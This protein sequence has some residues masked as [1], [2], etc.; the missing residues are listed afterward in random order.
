MGFAGLLVV[1]GS[2]KA[3]FSRPRSLFYPFGGGA[4]L[5]GPNRPATEEW[6]GPIP[7]PDGCL[8]VRP[9]PGDVVIMAELLAHGIRPWSST[10]RSRRAM[11]IRFKTGAAYA[12]HMAAWQAKDD[13][14]AAA[15]PD[16]MLRP[17]RLHG[18][19]SFGT[20]WEAATLR[21]ASAATLALIGGGD[22]RL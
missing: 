6:H 1:P 21:A 20:R 11:A 12:E 19:M 8:H 16:W 18:G 7:V 4:G 2:R 15:L 3:V 10:D 17:E 14:G 5:G 22:A 13:G 9:E